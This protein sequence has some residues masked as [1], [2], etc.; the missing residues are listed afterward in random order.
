MEQEMALEVVEELGMEEQEEVVVEEEKGKEEEEK[1]EEEEEEEEVRRGGGRRKQVW[2][3]R[4]QD[5]P[6]CT[7]TNIRTF[8]K[9]NPISPNQQIWLVSPIELP[10]HAWSGG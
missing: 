5:L 4:S 2:L 10:G 6:S 1:K 7:R 3:P 9:T 8:S